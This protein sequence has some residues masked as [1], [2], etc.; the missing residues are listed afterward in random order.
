[1]RK[2]LHLTA[3]L[4]AGTGIALLV[5]PG[6]VMR[7]LLGLNGLGAEIALAR[8]L[9]IALLALGVACWS[10]HPAAPDAPAFRAMLTYNLLVA[11]LLSYL[12]V[13]ERYFGLLLWPAVLLHFGL[14]ALL[15]RASRMPPETA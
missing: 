6:L 7:L 12:G 11:I 10:N 1:M 15:I 9:G 14:T 4:E 13:V 8:F 5:I 2:L 3:V